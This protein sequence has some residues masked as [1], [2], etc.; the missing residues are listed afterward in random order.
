MDHR[1]APVPLAAASPEDLSGG[2]SAADCRNSRRVVMKA[3]VTGIILSLDRL[4][5]MSTLI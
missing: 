2:S 5:N 4:R 3:P 1:V